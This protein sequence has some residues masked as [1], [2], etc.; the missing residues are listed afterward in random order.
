MTSVQNAFDLVGPSRMSLLNPIWQSDQKR[1][2]DYIYHDKDWDFYLLQLFTF[3][4]VPIRNSAIFS[5]KWLP[6]LSLENV[7]YSCD[8]AVEICSLRQ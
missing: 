2:L 6:I 7:L 8:V 1:D 5:V 3:V 4:Q